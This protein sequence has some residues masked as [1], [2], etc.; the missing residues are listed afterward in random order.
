MNLS[1]PLAKNIRAHGFAAILTAAIALIGITYTSPLQ[2]EEKE[3]KSSA[4]VALGGVTPMGEIRIELPAG[5]PLTIEERAGDTLRVSKGPF[6]GSVSLRQTTLWQPTPTPT[7]TASTTPSPTPAS[8]PDATN[9]DISFILAGWEHKAVDFWGHHRGD[10]VPLVT[11]IALIALTLFLVLII[12]AIRLRGAARQQAQILKAE[13]EL[14]R[15]ELQELH[16][17]LDTSRKQPVE[18]ALPQ[19]K[20]DTASCPHCEKTVSLSSLQKGVNIC[21]GC[22]GEFLYE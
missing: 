22:G 3:T 17:L 19:P 16:T 12:A 8:T 2:A 14:V 9:R 5:T 11:A 7:P 15:R 13:L 18:V 10:S 6:S 4:P 1:T 21:S 20:V